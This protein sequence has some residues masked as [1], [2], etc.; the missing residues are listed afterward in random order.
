MANS[1]SPLKPTSFLQRHRFALFFFLFIIA[2]Q[3][4]VV[5]RLSP[6]KVDGVTYAFCSVDFS[7]GFATKLLP[8]A[9]F[10]ALFGE[11]S[12][13]TTASLFN[14]VLI[15][16]FFCG[17][18]FLLG[19]FLRRV[20]E[21]YRS[22]AV[23]LL[24]FYL[25]GPYTFAIFTD[26]LGM[27]D[28]YWL[29]FSLLFFLFLEHK[30]LRFFI[31]LLFIGSLMIHYSS[32]LNYIF[33]FCIVLLYRVCV[34]KEKKE[35]RVY[36][37]ILFV[38]VF[39]TA[40]AAVFFV[41][42]ESRS[43]CSMEEFH[44]LLDKYNSTYYLY[45]DYAF[46]D[47]FNGEYFIPE[48][49]A[50]MPGSLTKIVLTVLYR[51]RFNFGLIEDTGSPVVIALFGGTLLLLPVLYAFYKFLL[52][53]FRNPSNTLE[54][55]CFF[56]MI[57]QF[58]LMLTVAMMFSIDSNRWLTHEFLILFT[59]LL[60]VLYYNNDRKTAFFEQLSAHANELPVK[61]YLLGYASVHFWPYC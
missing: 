47:Y 50:S 52:R 58:P 35:R 22:A 9:I 54:R 40:A 2:Y 57:L 21:Q 44:R 12:N 37:S 46:Y 6:W 20:P 19:K 5:N 1:E 13:E 53:S 45:Y 31:P 3:V 10:H 29:F 55:F 34:A 36:L 39:V 33:L 49:V 60:T 43:V 28:V 25:T 41:L 15:L 32:L 23:L 59:C 4:I 7:C 14:V 30:V 16:L 18:S 24:V 17:L 26:V 11:N 61:L 8:G 38:S 48:H 42:T 51:I 27:L 56:L